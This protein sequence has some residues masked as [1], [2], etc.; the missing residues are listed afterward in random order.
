MEHEQSP[1]KSSNLCET[2]EVFSSQKEKCNLNAWERAKQI[3]GP[4]QRA[5]KKPT[6]AH[7]F[8]QQASKPVTSQPTVPDILQKSSSIFKESKPELLPPV[9]QISQQ[10]EASTSKSLDRQVDTDVPLDRDSSHLSFFQHAS[11]YVLPDH[12]LPSTHKISHNFQHGSEPEYPQSVSEIDEKS[13]GRSSN[14]GERNVGVNIPTNKDTAPT[15]PVVK[16]VP[17]FGAPRSKIAKFPAVSGN[18]SNSLTSANVQTSTKTTGSSGIARPNFNHSSNSLFKRVSS[19]KNPPNASESVA[20][21]QHGTNESQC[22]MTAASSEKPYCNTSR[23][24][25]K[26]TPVKPNFG[27]KSVSGTRP[28]LENKPG[29]RQR[30]PGLFH[31][32]DSNE[33]CSSSDTKH[34]PQKAKTSKTDLGKRPLPKV[35]KKANHKPQEGDEVNSLTKVK[36]EIGIS[37]CNSKSSVQTNNSAQDHCSDREQT[38]I[39]LL[40][41]KSCTEPDTIG[42]PSTNIK[43]R[44]AFKAKSCE[45]R[46]K[47]SNFNSD[48]TKENV[49]ISSETFPSV[50][51]KC[52]KE[53]PGCKAIKTCKSAPSSIMSTADWAYLFNKVIGVAAKEDEDVSSTGSEIQPNQTTSCSINNQEK[54]SDQ[55]DDSSSFIDVTGSESGVEIIPPEDRCIMSFMS[56]PS[57]VHLPELCEEGDDSSR[58]DK[59]VQVNNNIQEKEK[60]EK[61]KKEKEKKKEK[62]EKKEKKEKEEKEKKEKEGII[63][64][65]QPLKSSA[66]LIVKHP[67]NSQI[68]K[69]ITTESQPVR[70]EL[71]KKSQEPLKKSS[72]TKRKAN[73]RKHRPDDES[74]SEFSNS[75]LE[76]SQEDEESERSPHSTSIKE[77]VVEMM[78]KVDEILWV[79]CDDCMKWRKLNHILDPSTLPKIWTCKMIPIKGKNNCQEPEEEWRQFNEAYIYN[80]FV[81]GSVVWA[82]V[83]GTEWWPGMVDIDPDYKKYIWLNDTATAPSYYHVTFF[84]EPVTRSWVTP[85]NMKSFEEND[86]FKRFY[87]GTRKDQQTIPLL[88]AAVKTAHQALGMD[89]RSRRKKFAFVVR[90][91][92]KLT[93]KRSIASSQ[94]NHT[95]SKAKKRKIS[96]SHEKQS[97]SLSSVCTN[98]LPDIIPTGEYDSSKVKTSIPVKK[99]SPLKRHRNTSTCNAH[100]ISPLEEEESDNGCDKREHSQKGRVVC[101]ERGTFVQRG[102]NRDEQKGESVR[103]M[104]EYEDQYNNNEPSNQDGEYKRQDDNDNNYQSNKQDNYE[105]PNKEPNF[106]GGGNDEASNT[107][108]Q[109]KEFCDTETSN[110]DSANTNRRNEEANNEDG[111]YTEPSNKDDYDALQNKDCHYEDPSNEVEDNEEPNNKDGN[112]EE[113]SNKDGECEEPGIEDGE[114]PSNK[115]GDCEEPSNEDGEE[116]SN[117]D[118]EEPSNEDGEEPSNE[119]GEEPSNEDGEEPSNEDGEEPSNEDGEEP[120]NEDGEEPSNEDGEEPSN[121]DG[122]CEEPGNEDGEEPSNEDDDC[123]EPGNEDGD[124]EEPSNE[125]GDCKEPSNEDGDCE[126]PSNKDGEEPSNEGGDCEE[127]SNED[128][129][130][131]EPSNEDG[132]EPS[133][134]DGEEPSNEDGDYEEPSNEDGEE[135]SNEDGEEPGNEDGEELSNEDGDCEEPS[136]EDGEEPSNE[137]GEEPGNED[138]EEPSNED[139]EEPSNEDGEEPSNEDGDYEEPSNEDGEEPGNEDGE[140]LSNE[141]GEEP[142]N[143]DGEEPSNEDGEEPSNEDGEEPGNED[144]EELSNE[145]GEEPSNEDGE[146]PSNEDGEEFSNEDGDC[147]EPSNEDGE[148]PSIEYGEEPSNEDGEEFSNDDGE[149]FSNED[150]EEPSNEDGDCEELCN[151]DGDCEELCN[152]DGEEPSNEDGDCEEL[153]NEDGEEPSNEDGDCE[154]PS[155]EDGDCEEPCNEDGEEPSNENGDC[156]ELCNEDGE[157]PSNE[158]GEEP[159]NEDGDCEEPSN[160]DSDCE[161]PCNEDGEKPSNE[162]GDYEEPCNIDGDCEESSNEDGDCEELR[163][164]DYDYKEPSNEDGD[165]EEPSNEDGDCEEPSNED[166]DCEEPS[167]ED[168]DSEEPSNEDGDCEEPSNEDGDYEKPRNKDDYKDSSNEIDDK[169]FI[170]DAVDIIEPIIEASYSAESNNKNSDNECSNKHNDDYNE[171]SDN[172]YEEHVN[173]SFEHKEKDN[174]SWEYKKQGDK[175]SVE[176]EDRCK[177]IDNKHSGCECERE[178]YFG[179]DREYE[180][181]CSNVYKGQGDDRGVVERGKI[182]FERRRDVGKQDDRDGDC[183]EC[184]DCVIKRGK[185]ASNIWNLKRI[186]D[187]EESGD[188]EDGDKKPDC[189]CDMSFYDADGED[190]NFGDSEDEWYNVKGHKTIRHKRNDFDIPEACCHKQC[191]LQ[192][193]FEESKHKGY[194]VQRNLYKIDLQDNDIATESKIKKTRHNFKEIARE[195]RHEKCVCLEACNKFF[196]SGGH[197]RNEGLSSTTQHQEYIDIVPES[198]PDQPDVLYS[199]YLRTLGIPAGVSPRDSSCLPASPKVTQTLCGCM[200][201]AFMYRTNSPINENQNDTESPRYL[202]KKCSES[203]RSFTSTSS[204]FDEEASKELSMR[205]YELCQEPGVSWKTNTEEM[206]STSSTSSELGEL[207]QEIPLRY[208]HLGINC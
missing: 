39:S 70:K 49:H 106:V 184:G 80:Q 14:S 1:Q 28:Q 117:E 53:V 198:Q 95:S 202:V 122:D 189:K 115:D 51:A 35:M 65:S 150:G 108:E 123:E 92:E 196:K 36:E 134:E 194:T 84:G 188:S 203:D 186:S 110:E 101:S 99:P 4:F 90:F 207:S 97:A 190:E 13:E 29:K 17:T 152:E 176:Y 76:E 22:E 142:S 31:C 128:G 145:D 5:S 146:E 6:G 159:S 34:I 130:Y 120:S 169:E 125:D 88:K 167:N 118:G 42:V 157:E 170:N 199:S 126:E 19:N 141:D 156:E 8:F 66:K 105:K 193:D 62:E 79:Q 129:D 162:D 103:E 124:C 78:E 104:S 114:E 16:K 144:G 85:K 41:T 204:F 63:L 7:S 179:K 153:C 64:P 9:P 18:A 109:N 180:V 75:E 160:E 32:T 132:E 86:T 148:E 46:T 197:M 100:D 177:Y 25:K 71:H 119:D 48:N 91:T 20:L 82:R 93:P 135:P 12:V 33:T 27:K 208:D 72:S 45:P 111:D 52:S 121:E 183:E 83:P 57:G 205:S 154:E 73:R 96:L 206:D 133:N 102:S 112:K 201:P 131:E 58:I 59:P 158:D 56:Q 195:N 191:N 107:N 147:E 113:P 89:V 77:Q 163:N 21:V 61:E 2:S 67:K 81:M 43:K 55:C 60:K 26:I 187:N 11:K 174:N 50:K 94:N 3:E 200:T 98:H 127:P 137:D 37:Q 181:N 69:T 140:E 138:G 178:R 47:Q 68:V 116:P 30:S 151:E 139:G 15:V 155:N 44:P 24:E 164:I 10:S 172:E 74:S 143:E 192:C 54:E 23:S 182:D 38:N 165:N 175:N 166:G 161:E 185:E 136:N 149:E 173:N 40:N 171:Q 168:G 87:F